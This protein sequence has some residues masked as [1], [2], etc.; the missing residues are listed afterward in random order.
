LTVLVNELRK[1][2][3]LSQLE[4]FLVDCLG[5]EKDITQKISSSKLREQEYLQARG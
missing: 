5:G 3:G 1:E 4:I 2:N